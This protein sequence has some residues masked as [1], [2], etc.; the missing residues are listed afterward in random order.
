MKHTKAT[1]YY[2]NH[3]LITT[4]A[5]KHWISSA[6][7]ASL[8]YITWL[9]RRPSLDPYVRKQSPQ[10]SHKLPS[11]SQMLCM[12]FSVVRRCHIQHQFHPKVGQN[13]P[14]NFLVFYIIH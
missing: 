2:R 13:P 5:T 8:Q 7:L 1:I 14:N 12:S 9:C 3:R 4:N 10:V 6:A 11:S